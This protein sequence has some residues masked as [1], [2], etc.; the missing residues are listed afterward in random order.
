MKQGNKHSFT[1]FKNNYKYC[2][3]INLPRP[4]GIYRG[5]FQ[6]ASVKELC[7]NNQRFRN[8]DQNIF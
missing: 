1:Y 2:Y 5:G 6:Q 3:F 4:A 7:S 8:F